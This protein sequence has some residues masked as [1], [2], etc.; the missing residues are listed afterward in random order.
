MGDWDDDDW[1]APDLEL[2]VPDEKQV[3]EWS[4]EEGHDPSKDVP[5][6]AAPKPRAEPK[7]KTGL[8]LK[9]E[10]REKREAEEAKRKAELRDSMGIAAVD[11]SGLDEAAAEKARRE[12]LAQLAD[13]DNA[14]DAFG[15]GGTAPKVADPAAPAVGQPAERGK[16]RAENGAIE[17][18]APK[19][20]KEFEELAGMI[21]DKLAT[22]E[23][24][25]GHMVLLKSLL[26]AA[27]SKLGTDDCKEISS[28]AT[29]IY[30]DKVKAD[31]DRD[32][33]PKKAKGA[34]RR[35]PAR[36]PPCARASRCGAWRQPSA[37]CFWRAGKKI[38]VSAGKGVDMD[39]EGGGGGGEWRGNDDFDFM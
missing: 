30:N 1:E 2:K 23:G 20:D 31:R 7:E 29:V 21:N 24:R 3:E 38:N 28:L 5:E 34:P 8:A 16:R 39:F 27:T 14:I 37:R 35:P 12:Q 19:S 10:E 15:L 4:D 9:I 13:L 22:F 17:A 36:A 18:F 33:K 32:K 6:E 26:R 25:K 11:T